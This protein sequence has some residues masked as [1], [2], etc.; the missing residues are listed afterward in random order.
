MASTVYPTSLDSYTTKVNNVDIYDASHIND[1]QGAIVA[2]ETQL[3]TTPKGTS[4]SVAE[5][6]AGIR[7]LSGAT[8]DTLI[9][10][11][12]N[13]GIGGTPTIGVLHVMANSS[14]YISVDNCM[15][16]TGSLLSGIRVIRRR[17]TIASPAVVQ[18]GDD[19]GSIIFQGYDGSQVRSAAVI[20]CFVD[21]I[22]GTNDMPGRLSFQTTPDG[23]LAPAERMRIDNNGNLVMGGSV[24]LGTTA[25]DGFLYIPTCA[26]TPTGAPTAYTGMVPIVFDTTAGKLWVRQAGAWKGGTTP[27]AFV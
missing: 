25:T 21:A 5:R 20:E 1:L 27:G 17:G 15:A 24:A 11:G 26:G 13:V 14:P 9:V 22:P 8:A 18:S 3:G 23:S 2:I 7:S 10:S 6:I 16:S 19:V 12:A 4:A